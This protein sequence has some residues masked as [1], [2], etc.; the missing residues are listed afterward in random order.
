[1][2]FRIIQFGLFIVFPLL[3]VLNTHGNSN[4]L[5]ELGF[6]LI[7]LQATYVIFLTRGQGASLY[8]VYF[9]FVYIFFGIIPWL[10]YKFN[11]S[12]WHAKFYPDEYRVLLNIIIITL[13]LTVTFIYSHYTSKNYV[14]KKYIIK[15]RFKIEKLDFL[16][17]L[18]IVLLAL[19]ALFVTLQ[20][21]D[22]NILRLLY[23]GLQ[24]DL[25]NQISI[26]IPQWMNTFLNSSVRFFS[27][28]AS[29]YTF[30]Y[31]KKSYIVKCIL[32]C[33][34]LIS[35]FPLG[36]P[37]FAAAALYLPL[38]ILL[39]PQL[40][41][42][43]N[44]SFLLLFGIVYVFPIINQF[45]WYKEGKMLQSGVDF[46][47]FFEGHF[48][49]YQSFLMI[50]SENFVTYGHQLLGVLFFY[51]PRGLW[52]DKPIGSGGVIAKEFN[53]SWHNISA[54]FFAEG[55]INFGLIGCYLFA[56]LLAFLMAKYDNKMWYSRDQINGIDF[57]RPFYLIL[58]GFLFFILRG[59]LMSSVS[60]LISILLPS[61]LIYFILKLN[62]SS[63][64]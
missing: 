42:G 49:S 18:I 43:R 60:F 45:R 19:V 7:I 38:L 28:I 39:F 10:E 12:Y 57:F 58:I 40:S 31:V 11:I 1:M 9:V 21:K 55:Y 17:S 34:A 16:P 4:F 47:F 14:K 48:D 59:D 24:E 6:F 8:K 35:A 33:A 44:F 5:I 53:L 26:G 50:V 54:N 36:I 22:F 30:Y 51:I 32:L 52:S 20:L 25:V 41:K 62:K 64:I 61:A 23:R 3:I 46:S 13:S 29:I 15:H 2:Y 37:R 56:F 63:N 27:V